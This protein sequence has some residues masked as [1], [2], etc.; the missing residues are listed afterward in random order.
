MRGCLLKTHAEMRTVCKH[1]PDD[2]CW[3][4]SL[5]M[6]VRQIDFIQFA[7]GREISCILFNTGVPGNCIDAF[8]EADSRVSTGCFGLG[9]PQDVLACVGQISPGF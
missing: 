3:P 4:T 5:I 9:C 8:T 1:P 7:T 2:Q 6:S